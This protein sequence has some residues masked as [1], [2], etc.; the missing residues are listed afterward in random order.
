MN[1]AIKDGMLIINI[2]VQTPA[3]LSKSRKSRVIASTNGNVKLPSLIVDGKTVTI[4]INAYI[5]A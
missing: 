2:P 4:G 5:P 3:P 1:A